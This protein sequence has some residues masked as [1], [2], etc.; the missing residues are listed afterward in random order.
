M[1]EQPPPHA[2]CPHCKGLMTRV[3]RLA[4]ADED[5]G[6]ALDRLQVLEGWLY[7][8][9]F[10]P[11]IHCGDLSSVAAPTRVFTVELARG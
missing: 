10:C 9:G 11:V 4:L 6:A 2:P 5:R 3:S 1:T 8:G 7:D